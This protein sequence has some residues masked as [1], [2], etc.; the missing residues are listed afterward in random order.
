[1]RIEARWPQ[2]LLRAH[3]LSLTII[4]QRVHPIYDICPI[5]NAYVHDG[6]FC[7]CC[8]SLSCYQVYSSIVLPLVI[9]N[10]LLYA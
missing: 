10:I 1:M 3:T 8:D 4:I 6:L 2:T 7:H 5:N 9:L